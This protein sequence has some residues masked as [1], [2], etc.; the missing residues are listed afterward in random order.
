MGGSKQWLMILNKKKIVSCVEIGFGEEGGLWE[1]VENRKRVK[2]REKKCRRKIVGERNCKVQSTII[3]NK[4]KIK[5][6]CQPLWVS[7]VKT[8]NYLAILVG[9]DRSDRHKY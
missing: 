7:R 2:K 4:E 6:N 3:I 9:W 8:N 5:E 1:I